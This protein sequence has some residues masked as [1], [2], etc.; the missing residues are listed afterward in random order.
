MKRPYMHNVAFWG[1]YPIMQSKFYDSL[2]VLS[3]YSFEQFDDPNA[4]LDKDK[5]LTAWA[6]EFN[7]AKYGRDP[8]YLTGLGPYKVTSWEPGQTLTLERKQNH[9]TKGKE[10]IYEASYP[11]KIIFKI[12]RDAN[13]QMLEFKSQVNDASTSVSTKTLLELQN[14]SVFNTNYHSKFVD[15]YYYTYAGMNMKPDGI[16]HKKLFDEHKGRKIEYRSNQEAAKHE[17]RS[18]PH[19]RG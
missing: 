3:K 15:T 8:Q 12:N 18:A 5:K 14:D 2:N 1:D 7:S 4:K 19:D 17:S 13:A 9:W 6:N 11:E 10:N 16:K